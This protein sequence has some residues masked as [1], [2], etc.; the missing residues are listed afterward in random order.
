M[1]TVVA[2][3]GFHGASMGAVAAEAAVAAGTAYVHYES[4][5][6]L[7]FATYL[8]VKRDLGSAALAGVE[9]VDPVADRFGRVWH[10]VYEHLRAEPERARFLAQVDASPYAE[11]AHARAMADLHDP[12]VAFAAEPD[13]ASAL[14]PLPFLVLWDLAIGPAVRVV[15]RDGHLEDVA[16]EALAAACWRAV[17]T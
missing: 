9:A 12:L 6:E 1:R 7:V 5:D 17:T 16:V 4:K 3:R 10:N 15:A 14:A 2:E 8:E 11:E 13:V